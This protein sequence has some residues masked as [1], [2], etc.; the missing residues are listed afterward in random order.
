M[1]GL[2]GTSENRVDSMIKKMKQKL[3]GPPDHPLATLLLC[4]LLDIVSNICTVRL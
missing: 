2:P 1:R 3:P 4:V